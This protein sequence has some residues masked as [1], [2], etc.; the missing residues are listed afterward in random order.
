[1]HEN[2]DVTNYDIFA[3]QLG[4]VSECMEMWNQNEQC[5]AF[6]RVKRA[7][8]KNQEGNFLPIGQCYFKNI[9]NIYSMGDILSESLDN[10]NLDFYEKQGL[11]LQGSTKLLQ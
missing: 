6:V 4:T 1:M 11:K 8:Q 3:R 5:N 7:F 9:N 10:F 2:K